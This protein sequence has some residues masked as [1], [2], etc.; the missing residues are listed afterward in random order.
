MINPCKRWRGGAD[1]ELKG[2][3]A[4]FD[5]T[6]DFVVSASRKCDGNLLHYAIATTKMKYDKVKETFVEEKS[7]LQ[8]LEE[9]GYDLSTLKFSIKKIK[10]EVSE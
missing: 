7:L 9:R 2:C 6:P 4:K 10:K 5:G 1:D 8:E 3:W